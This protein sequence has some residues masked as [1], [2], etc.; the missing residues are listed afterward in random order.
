MMALALGLPPTAPG[1]L[2]AP[3]DPRQA[4]SYLDKLHRWRDELG[5]VLKSADRRAQVATA[6]DEFTGDL[7]LAMSLAESIDRRTDELIRV[8]DGG[9]VGPQQLARL[10]QLI[11]SR[12]PDSLGDLIKQT[13]VR[14]SVQSQAA[15][16]TAR[17]SALAELEVKVHELA[18]RCRDKLAD[19]PRVAVP[20]PTVLG[21]VPPIPDGPAQPGAWTKSR[22]E[23]DTYRRR[24]DQVA[25]ALTEAQRRY[26]APLTDRAEL[27][28]LAEASHTRLKGK[29]AGSAAPEL[30]M[31]GEVR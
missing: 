15:E 24:A 30:G 28:G 26:A 11:W 1:S 5:T 31:K 12:L 27:R 16:H 14:A 20:D 2:T 10:A 9:R 6:T 3:P 18:A 13:S 17:L 8:W 25:A 19:P 22:A 21:R 23:L 7:T 29:Q 4:L